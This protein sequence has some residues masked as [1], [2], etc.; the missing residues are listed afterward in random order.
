MSWLYEL[1]QVY[2]NTIKRNSDEKPTPIYH[3]SNNASVTVCFVTLYSLYG[4]VFAG[5]LS[6]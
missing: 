1:S 5:T 3:I 4:V 2:D 6:S